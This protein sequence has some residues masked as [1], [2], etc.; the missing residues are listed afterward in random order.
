MRNVSVGI[1]GAGE[2]TRKLHLPVLLSMPDVRIAWLCDSRQPQAQMVGAAYGIRATA[3]VTIESLPECDVA[4]L[5]IPV[6]ARRDY[7]ELFRERGIPVLCEKPFAA[8]RSDHQDLITKFPSYALGVG[9]QRR[10]YASTTL[11]RDVLARGWFGELRS[12]S[13]KEGDRSRGSGVDHS[14]LDDGRAAHTR[15]VLFDLGT[16]GI[17][18]VLHLVSPTHFDVLDCEVIS[19]AGV[20]RRVS[21]RVALHGSRNAGG[22]VVEFNY[23]VSWLDRQPNLLRLDFERT[24]LWCA[25]SPSAEVHIGDPDRP[26]ESVRIVGSAGARTPNQAFYLEWRAFL[27]GVH[28]RSDSAL[29]ARSSLL[30]TGLMEDLLDKGKTF[31]G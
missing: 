30:T 24:T 21:A 27:E 3:P 20:D 13:L 2:I 5:A 25:L 11:L 12:I 10:F 23:C 18:L 8:S 14:F 29:S 17:D 15:G 16:H 9:Y 28:E 6:E 26:A 31:H 19:D 4:L 1:V 7:L 22:N